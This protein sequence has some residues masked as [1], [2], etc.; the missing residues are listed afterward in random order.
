M[1]ESLQVYRVYQEAEH[2][3]TAKRLREV[4]AGVEDIIACDTETTGL[5]WHGRYHLHDGKGGVEVMRG[6]V[7]FGISLAIPMEEK[8]ALCWARRGTTLWGV[9]KQVL[10]NTVRKTWHNAR[11]DIRVCQDNQIV[12]GGVQDDTLTMSRIWWDRRKAHGL[13]DL[14][15][16]VCPH[17]C[18]WKRE[19]D[20]EW[21]RLQSQCTREKRPEGY[22]NYSL[23]PN[24]LVGAYAKVDAFMGLVLW[25]RLWEGVGATELYEREMRVLHV[26]LDVEKRGL[27]FDSEKARGLIGP[28][29]ERVRECLAHMPI[30]VN[31]GSPAQVLE[32]LLA[33]GARKQDLTLKGKLTTGVEVLRDLIK[34]RGDTPA[35]VLATDILEYRALTKTV[36]TYLKKFADM[37][38]RQSG[39]IYTT[40]NPAD[41]KTGRMA[42]R[43]PNLMNIPSLHPRGSGVEEENPTR[44]CF[45]PREGRYW[46]LSD[47][48]Q[49]ELALF[50]WY[51]QDPFICQ[52]YADGE[53]VHLAMAKQIYG[54]GCTPDQRK[55]SKNITFGVVYGMQEKKL[56]AYLGLPADEARDL[57]DFYHS[58]F[59]S[60]HRFQKEVEERLSLDGHVTDWFKNIVS[61]RTKR[62]RG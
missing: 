30:G 57:L 29:E 49:M 62:I 31:P 23:M 2:I 54:D 40:I 35:A 3:T 55:L 44:S 37:A 33:A 19:F 7:P 51:T 41:T 17:L 45:G 58:R 18:E 39:L 15:E 4:V 12:L 38:D 8:V 14:T 53:D 43:N 50:G 47:Y 11:Y 13:E 28:M 48:S 5:D 9:A 60:I 24:E 16:M 20:R 1:N 59:P 6:V 32:G 25:Y 61:H 42:S 26:I 52:A 10:G 36:N 34:R 27:H 46:Y 21:R 56:I 22:C